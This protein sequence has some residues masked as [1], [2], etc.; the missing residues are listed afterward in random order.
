M[1]CLQGREALDLVWVS[2]CALESCSCWV[3]RKQPGEEIC[4]AAGVLGSRLH[5]QLEGFLEEGRAGT[6]HKPGDKEAE[7]KH[8]VKGGKSLSSQASWLLLHFLGFSPNFQP[9]PF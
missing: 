3:N 1:G 6:G 5:W 9:G 2:R 8:T 7:Q 4:F